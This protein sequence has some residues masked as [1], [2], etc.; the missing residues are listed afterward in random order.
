MSGVPFFSITFSVSLRYD[1]G[2]F[3]CRYYL[4][5]EQTGK[6]TPSV[7]VDGRI[8]L[9]FFYFFTW[10]V[11]KGKLQRERDK[12][13]KRRAKGNAPSTTLCQWSLLS[14]CQPK[15]GQF[16]HPFCCW[17][18]FDKCYLFCLLRLSFPFLLLLH[19]GIYRYEL[20]LFGSFISQYLLINSW[21]SKKEKKTREILYNMM[22]FRIYFIAANERDKSGK[23]KHGQ[24]HCDVWDLNYLLL[25]WLNFDQNPWVNNEKVSFQ[26]CIWDFKTSTFFKRASFARIKIYIM[27]IIQFVIL[28]QLL[29]SRQCRS[30]NKYYNSPQAG[31]NE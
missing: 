17:P 18:N 19:I 20:F 7:R 16:F 5:Y 29:E 13:R 23:K 25:I 2:F 30:Y 3:Y 21:Y 22:K 27:N 24:K 9:F 31:G 4:L 12:E 6:V 8:V 14:F 1:P 11:C 28:V 15:L 26:Y 10:V